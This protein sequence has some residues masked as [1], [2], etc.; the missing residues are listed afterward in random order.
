[1]DEKNSTWSIKIKFKNNQLKCI[2]PHLFEYIISEI[3]SVTEF[4]LEM[5][6]NDKHVRPKNRWWNIWRLLKNAEK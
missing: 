4:E 5:T 1:M 6:L 3:N 2:C